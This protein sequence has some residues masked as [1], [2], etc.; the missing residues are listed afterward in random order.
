MSLSN[1]Q[2]IDQW[3]VCLNVCFKAK[4]K[5]YEHLLYDVLLHDNVNLLRN[6][7]FCLHNF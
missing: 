1:E 5:H 7:Y 6:L 3:R 2:A 4:G